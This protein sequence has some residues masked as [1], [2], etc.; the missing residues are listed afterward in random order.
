[1]KIK[2]SAENISVFCIKIFE[3]RI[4]QLG[5]SMKKP[6]R[7]RRPD[8]Q[9]LIHH[10]QTTS[11]KSRSKP[12]KNMFVQ[13]SKSIRNKET[14]KPT[15]NNLRPRRHAV[16]RGNP[17]SL[18]SRSE[19]PGE[20]FCPGRS[21]VV[22]RKETW[23]K[24]KD[25]LKRWVVCLWTRD[26]WVKGYRVPALQESGRAGSVSVLKSANSFIKCS[27]YPCNLKGGKCWPK[28]NFLCPGKLGVQ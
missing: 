17:E 18:S 6:Q 19:A 10:Q 8:Y 9:I 16:L 22:R 25:V 12:K 28:K 26:G 21:H 5:R 2:A 13:F 1:M 3:K 27:N 23:K 4:I 15:S 20:G 7:A 24:T 14:A 11:Q